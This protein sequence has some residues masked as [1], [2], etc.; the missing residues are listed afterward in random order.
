MTLWKVF[1]KVLL[2]RPATKLLQRWAYQGRASPSCMTW[3]Q[4]NAYARRGPR[5]RPGASA[6]KGQVTGSSQ[7][8]PRPAQIDVVT[9]APHE[10]VRML[11]GSQPRPLAMRHERLQIST[12][13]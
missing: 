11:A 12:P 2:A 7:D 3:Q 13:R 9:K 6:G 4:R 10:K 8:A 1:H 5:Y